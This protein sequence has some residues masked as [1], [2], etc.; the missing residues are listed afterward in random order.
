MIG[1]VLVTGAKG[2]IGGHIVD[3]LLQRKD[4]KKIKAIQYIIFSKILFGWQK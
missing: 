1:N 4:V 3:Q 2:F